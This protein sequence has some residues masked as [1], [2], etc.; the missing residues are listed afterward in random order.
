M[1]WARTTH[2]DVGSR[3]VGVQHVQRKGLQLV[4]HAL[5]IANRN[6][7]DV[8][9]HGH[10]KQ[11]WGETSGNVKANANLSN[12]KEIYEFLEKTIEDLKKH[13]KYNYGIPTSGEVTTVNNIKWDPVPL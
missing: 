2:E 10:A 1:R 3:K 8:L 9:E 6:Y 13:K 12:Q 11:R 7:N 4:Q 5:F